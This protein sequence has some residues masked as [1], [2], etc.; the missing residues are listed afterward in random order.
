MFSALRDNPR[1]AY[2]ANGA[3]KCSTK[4]SRDEHFAGAAD[5][6][7]ACPSTLTMPHVKITH[8]KRGEEVL[9]LIQI[10]DAVTRRINLIDNIVLSKNSAIRIETLNAQ[11]VATFDFLV[12]ARNI[13]KRIQKASHGF[14]KAKQ[15]N[16]NL[17]AEYI[18]VTMLDPTTA[19]SINR[20]NVADGF[21]SKYWFEA[22][23]NNIGKGND[24][25]HGLSDCVVK[26]DL[27]DMGYSMDF[28]YAMPPNDANWS[29]TC[30]IHI[31][32]E[33]PKWDGQEED[34]ELKKESGTITCRKTDTRIN[35][36]KAEIV[37]V[38]ET[39]HDPRNQKRA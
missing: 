16:P 15:Q 30:M 31:N 6:A 35:E 25:F 29:K 37:Q 19:S 7:K 11:G 28:K 22:I 33:F 27:I 20:G 36:E 8:S 23:F 13:S 3:Y 38:P 2:L 39:C 4:L 12:F 26:Q 14:E 17:D 5:G 21:R 10:G 9:C 24:A 34:L 18:R 32:K 1:C